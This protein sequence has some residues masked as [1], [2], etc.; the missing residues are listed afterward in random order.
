MKDLSAGVEFY[1]RQ[2]KGLGDYFMDTLFSDI[3]SLLLHAG[4]HR[5]MFGYFRL[6]SHRFPFAV[7]Y[8]IKTGVIEVWRVLDCRKNPVTIR[9]SLKK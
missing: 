3:D 8:Q 7:Y 4:V 9:S 1:E 2:E 6:I 5:Q